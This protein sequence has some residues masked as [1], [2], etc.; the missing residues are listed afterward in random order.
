MR[1]AQNT[2]LG[3]RFVWTEGHT[4][5]AAVLIGSIA[6]IGYLALVIAKLMGVV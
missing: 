6:V 3:N 5:W 4:E 1:L 2:P